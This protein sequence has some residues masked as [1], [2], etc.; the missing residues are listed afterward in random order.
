VIQLKF[1]KLIFIWILFTFILI[2]L[3]A[4]TYYWVGGSGSWSQFGT[5][6][7]T[8]SGGS[9]FHNQ[10]P[11]PLDDVIFDENSFSAGSQTVTLDVHA[12]SKDFSWINVGFNPT[13]SCGGFNLT[14]SGNY[15]TKYGIF[16]L[17]QTGNFSVS[18]SMTID[19]A[20]MIFN[21]TAGTFSV[22]GA[23]N[24]TK[25]N[26]TF[27]TGTGNFSVGG[28]M[29]IDSA[30]VI[31][32]KTAGTFSVVGDLT[33]SNCNPSFTISSSSSI[34][35]NGNTLV[36][37]CNPTTFT[38][39][40]N[41]T[42]SFGGNVTFELVKITTLNWSNTATI[43]GNF[44][45]KGSKLNF[46]IGS[47]TLTCNNFSIL[48]S[49]TTYTQS[50]R[51]YVGGS[52]EVGA[53]TVF[54]NTNTVE[55]TASTIDNTITSNGK[56]FANVQFNGTGTWTLN[57]H[58]KNI[59]VST[60]TRGNLISNGKT[61]DFGINLD[62]S[63]SNTK[64]LNF[65][66]T[67]TVAVRN[68]WNIHSN[69]T[70][71][72]G[73]ATILLKSN[74]AESIT[75]SGGNKSYHNIVVQNNFNSG[76]YDVTFNGNNTFSD[77]LYQ[78]PNGHTG[79]YRRIYFNG[80]S[81]W[82]NVTIN[83]F[84][85]GLNIY[86]QTGP[87]T[88][89]DF[90]VNAPNYISPNSSNY[91]ISAN[92]INSFNTVTLSPGFYWQLYNG[93]NQQINFLNP[94]SS[95]AKSST[96]IGQGATSTITVPSGTVT[97]EFPVLNNHKVQGG[98]TFDATNATVIPTVTG[99]NL[100]T[101]PPLTLYW[102]GGTGNWNDVNRWS[103]TSGGA[104]NGCVFPTSNDNVIFDNNS[105]TAS[106]QTVSLTAT[107]VC[108]NMTWTS[109]VTQNPTFTGSFQLTIFGDLNALGT[110]TWVQ[111][112][113]LYVGGDFILNSNVNWN[114]AHY[115]YFQSDSTNNNINLAGKSLIHRAYFTAATANSNPKWTLL[116]NY[117]GDFNNITT[118]N[119][120][121]FIS[122]GYRVD[123][124]YNLDASSNHT[125]T[126]DFTGTDTVVVRF[127]WSIHANT[128]LTMATANLLFSSNQA[129]NQSM[130]GGNKT[131]HNVIIQNNYNSGFQSFIFSGNNTFNNLIYS[132]PTAHTNS[133]KQ[134]YFQGASTWNDV[135]INHYGSGLQLYFQTG[136]HTFNNFEV[137]V[138]NY[139]TPASTNFYI[140]ANAINTF[141]TFTITN[142][143]FYWQLY[144]SKNQQITSLNI[145]SHCVKRSTIIGGGVS[146]SI[147]AAGGTI[148]MDYPTLST[149]TVQGGAT[150]DAT[151]ATV[152]PVLTGW[153]YTTPTPKTLY[154]VGGSGNWNDAT[155]WAFTSGGSGNGCAYP[156]SIDTVLFDANSFTA[157][158]QTV[159][160]NEN[161]FTKDLSWI[162]VGFNPN[163]SCGSFSLNVAGNYLTKYGKFTFSQT[164]SF[165]VSGS[166]TID[167]ADVTFNK[168][169]GIFSVGG[170]LMISNCNPSF[171]LSS[172]SS[173][174]VTGNTLVYNCNPTTF[175]V[176][177]S[178]TATFGG[179]V[180]FELVKI[181]TLNWTN[182]A[183]IS[184]NFLLKGSK[185]NFNIGNR[186]LSCN[187]F[188]ILDSVTTFTQS[189]RLYVSGSFNLGELTVFNNTN[190]VEFNAASAGK[191][192][193]SNGKI[194][195]NAIFN[196][197]GS[198]TLQDKFTNSGL[199]TF[200]RGHFIS[201]GKS[202][203]F[204]Y[205]L[206][207]SVSNTRT[208]DF[209][210][211]D[212]ITVRNTWSIHTGT[213]LT[214]ATANL[215]FKSNQAESQT[216]SGGNKTYHNIVIQNNYNSGY[217]DIYFSGNNTIN[218]LIYSNPTGHTNS[219]RRIYFQG[220]STW[221]NVTI[222]HYGAGMQI[223]FQS[224]P[225]T[226]NDFILNVPNFIAPA[227]SNFLINANSVNTFN[228]F[229]ISN[230]GFYWQLNNSKNQQITNLSI[231][232]DC[233]KRSTIIG[234][235]VTSTITVPSGSIILEYPTLSTHAVQGGATFDA[236]DATI[237]PTVT[238]WNFTSPPPKTLYWVGGSGNWTDAT[239]WA[240][241][242]GGAGNGCAFPTSIDN[243]IF[244]ANSF[245]ANSQTVTLNA[246]AT[247]KDL[248]WI[249]VGFNPSL[250]CGSFNL[251][252]NGNYLNKYGK[253]TFSQTGNLTVTGS[254]TI[255][256][257]DISFSKTAG[258]LS[259]SG[260]LTIS[261]CN[262]S[263][264]NSSNSTFTVSGNTLV[265][266][267]N[268][269]TFTLGNSS[270]ATFGGNV[271]FELVKITTLNWSN[272]AT[273][274]GNFLLKGSKLNFN[275]G[276]RTLTCKSFS[277][278]DSVT[279][280]TQSNRLYVGGSFELGPLTVFNQTNTVEFTASTSGNTITSSGKSFPNVQFNGTGTWTL[281]DHFKN[282]N[283]STFTRGNLISN[284][285]TVDFG[286][287]LDASSSNTKS[288]N[289]TGTDTVA[290][291]NSWNVHSNTTI[292]MGTASILLKS[293]LAE[294]ITFTGG[295]KTYHNLVVQNNY[296][297][298]WYDVI[299]S[300]NNTFNTF[301]YANP[302]GHTNSYRRLY[303]QGSSNW[304][305]V[306]I[307]HYGAGLL[308]YFQTGPHTFN[309][310]TVNAPNFLAPAS[311][312]YYIDANAINSFNSFTLSPGFY[313][314]LYNSKNQ[315]INYLNPG[316]TCLKR[317]TIAGQSGTLSTI[318]VP[319]GTVNIDWAT[320]SNHKAQGGATFTATSAVIS[321][322]VNGWNAS[323][324]PSWNFYWVGGS[325][326]WSNSNNWAFTS[327]GPGNGCII[328]TAKDNVFFDGNSFTAANQTVTVNTTANCNN[329]IWNGSSSKTP[330]FSGSSQLTIN[331]DLVCN[332]IMTWNLSSILNLYG[333]ITLNSG[334]NWNQTNTVNFLANTTGKTINMAGKS[335]IRDVTFNGN[336]S[337]TLEGNYK[338]DQNGSYNTIFQKG[339]FISNGFSVE[340]GYR[341]YA[342]YNNII[343]FN[344]SGTD[345]IRIR[346]EWTVSTHANTTINTNGSIILLKT[347]L[348]ENITF[349]GGGKSYSGVTILST[350]TSNTAT[351][352]MNDNTNY[353][354]MSITTSNRKDVTI[355]GNCIFNDLTFSLNNN[356][357][358]QVTK[359]NFNG[360]NTF[361][362]ATFLSQGT[363]GPDITLANNNTIGSFVSGGR[364][365]HVFL[366]SAKTQTVTEFLLLGTGSY[367]A[368]L[369]AT[370]TG[371]QA[372]IVK[373]SGQVCMD[374]VWVKDINASG[375]AAFYAGASSQDLGNNTGWTFVESCVGYY[376]VGG[377]GNW[378]DAANHWAT[379]SAG[380]TFWAV[381]PDFSN[382]VY[383]DSNSFDA[384]GQTV[385]L[386][387][388]NPECKNMNWFSVFYSPTFSGSSTD[389]VN[390]YGDL[391]LSSSMNMSFNGKWRFK[392]STGDFIINTVGKILKDVVF[393][394]NYNG[395]G[396]NWKLTNSFTVSDS[397]H[398][399]NGSFNT[400]NH[401]VKTKFF[402]A[403]TQNTRSILLGSSQLTITDGAWK[404]NDA[405]N[406]SITPATSKI[407]L[408]SDGGSCN[409]TGGSKTYN[410]IDL[411]T[412]S[413]ISS[414]FKDSNTFNNF[415]L[416]PGSTLELQNGSVQ[417][418]T[419]FTMSGNCNKSIFIKSDIAGSTATLSQSTGL[420][421]GSF[422]F[423]KDNIASGGATFNANL[424][425]NQGNN[426]GW[427]FTDLQPLSL[428]M[429]KQDASC[430]LP[431]D[432]WAKVIANDGTP[433]YSYLWTTLSVNDSIF[434][435]IPNTY[436]V[437]V[438]DAL[439][440]IAI[441]SAIITQPS[442][443]GFTLTT[444]SGEI[445]PG[446]S[447]GVL[448]VSASSQA[449]YPL[450]YLWS[451]NATDSMPSNFTKGTF[452]VTVTDNANC[453]A[454]ASAVMADRGSLN[455][456][457]SMSKVPACPDE[458]IS[459][460]G[461][462]VQSGNALAFDGSNDYISIPASSGINSKIGSNEITLEAWIYLSASNLNDV[463]II[464]E[465]YLGDN[466]MSF[467]LKMTNQLAKAGFYNGSYREVISTSNI[468]LNSWTHLAATYDGSTIRLYINGTQNNSTNY[469]NTIPG[470][471]EEWRIGRRWDN[472]SGSTSYW[473]GRMDEIRIWNTARTAV[474]I[475][476]NM[477]NTIPPAT[478]GLVAY[479]RFNEGIAG[480]NNSGLD[481][482]SD[483]SGN[484]YKGTLFNFG[485]TGTTSN[486]ISSSIS[487]FVYPSTF[488]FNWDLGDTTTSNTLSLDKSYAYG[489]NKN[490]I[491]T[492]SDTF[493]CS[494]N[495]EELLTV[496]PNIIFTATGTDA[497]CGQCNASVTLNTSG[498]SVPYYLG[499][500]DANY[501]FPIADIDNSIFAKD[502]IITYTQNNQ[503]NLS[504]PSSGW[505]HYFRTIATY[506]RTAGKEF[507]FSFYQPSGNSAMIGWGQSST[508]NQN[509]N[510]YIDIL[511]AFYFQ[512]SNL[513]I[514]EDGNNRG[515]YAGLIPGGYSTNQWYD[516]RIILKATG[517]DYYLRKQGQTNY[518]LIYSSSYSSNTNLRL[519]MS[520]N[521]SGNNVSTDEWRILVPNPSSS[522][523][524]P[525]TNYTYGIIDFAGCTDDLIHTPGESGP[526]IDVKG[527][528]ISITDGDTTPDVSDSTDFGIAET[529]KTIIYKI[530]NSDTFNLIIP[531]GGIFMSGA[532][533]SFF[534]IGGITLPDTLKN[535]S[536]TFTVTFTPGSS[537]IKNAFVN[538]T[539]NDCDEGNYDFKVQAT[540]CIPPQFT[541][542]PG[543]IN[544]NTSTGNCHAVVSYSAIASGNPVPDYSYSFAG[545]T[546][547]SGNGT[548]S[549]AT[550]NKGLT[551]VTIVASNGC[552]PDASCQFTIDVLDNENPSITCPANITVTATTDPPACTYDV[553]NTS[554]DPASF[555][556]NCGGASI[557]NDFNN[558][559][560]LNGAT[561]PYGS[562]LIVW[563][564]TDGSSNSDT[565]SVAVQVQGSIYNM[566]QDIYFCTID[567]AIAASETQNNDELMIPAGT[568]TGCIH[569]IKTIKLMPMG[570][571]VLDCLFMEAPDKTMTLM[572]DITITDLTLTDGH[573]H[574]NGHNLKCGTI[575]GGDIG[576]Y[577]ITD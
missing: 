272:T 319:A 470:G 84:G 101:P 332:D 420:V 408:K 426:S 465:S 524:C 337:W 329:M 245:T 21:K 302:T 339:S 30:D 493:G 309:D 132:N 363:S 388:S 357:N 72:M 54:N 483:I 266:N 335:F 281:N 121:R 355:N 296:N 211:T 521:T 167:S 178:S 418:A 429:L 162:N 6:W 310:F 466:N 222:N 361:N 155:H 292:N 467:Y 391:T 425:T 70:I 299:I 434:G 100:I 57:D 163:F 87:H 419:Q 432:G 34:T 455:P 237:I 500:A 51:L 490:V 480:D 534:T 209:T 298:G 492:V 321:G 75:F 233:I 572:G 215:L 566:T 472:T 567:E 257:A 65:T 133:R 136:A 112:N 294:N 546:S 141:N 8:T 392:A 516:C 387:I 539:N 416:N 181:T 27:T 39:G 122:N 530:I 375:G 464:G 496:N 515:N 38:M 366:G 517:A 353:G 159:T 544:V 371:S 542:C 336:G 37:N 394:G 16:T 452:T 343:S 49:V 223:Y 147:T 427:V 349:N 50:S 219:Y 344:F 14:I 140:D 458:V 206:D 192:I 550:F 241:T 331:G 182:T 565:C 400:N 377:S 529:P 376:W 273:I 160:L 134:I 35:V 414:L 198:W 157:N 285:K 60:F 205:N 230:P 305:N 571:V 338:I 115:L 79:S 19:S 161:A 573:V 118:F 226:F 184:G 545:V 153:T 340:F 239:H 433:P 502:N 11:S 282:T 58:F 212:T 330:I 216:F 156:T 47:R 36:Y 271:T 113:L 396:A 130:A 188:S 202:V 148:I 274:T 512:T 410:N 32:S 456:V 171:N 258:T 277:I 300:G 254:M 559:N 499:F 431:N 196:G 409:F 124:G 56:S 284:G 307:N 81:T 152:V 12:F 407:I 412:N 98:A 532:D 261:N 290:V 246:N 240:L 449:E 401:A 288:L 138:P 235:G 334:I 90:V 99:W 423:I 253:Y 24:I 66:G 415:T 9:T 251:N 88:F 165:S 114:H 399:N 142:P 570:T 308:I 158:S 328:P 108:K 43:T 82:Q 195:S 45:L 149:H 78:N 373:S 146:S 362:S 398:L 525:N 286:I 259:V 424:S 463:Y 487:S 370:T 176:G 367:P 105:F 323:A 311:S 360:S 227:S 173:I 97:I 204:G 359:I 443:F 164:G 248:S 210:G 80:S 348:N 551:T 225:H 200:T 575:S 498:G 129:D 229:T 577:I 150:F 42:A 435:L 207:A 552:D 475:S 372:F 395:T 468:A 199:T 341:L 453:T 413:T 252:V 386:D 527:N 190:Y 102:V 67:D 15:L 440:C 236:T 220:S 193:T 506:P 244:D 95:C 549:G 40:N 214:M 536:T 71:N 568:Y 446:E 33:I 44:I 85:A 293:N 250:S 374:Y 116:A 380:S 350:H 397:I 526:E 172:S 76:W 504:I 187:D 183:N 531:S 120:G 69:T 1:L 538:I 533:A 513:G 547:G 354:N 109:G 3:N 169:G 154:W 189:N 322:T 262:P 18:G 93:K 445:C 106:G 197:T 238:G 91:Y 476:S 404:I 186:T 174:T 519:L 345:T 543:A 41:S 351:I 267:C 119:E 454:M 358:S 232:S 265:Y 22:G 52:F 96:I 508:S 168:T 279:T 381:P 356:D 333:S 402:N 406:L 151:N 554:L 73:T 478:Q 564:V 315:Q 486:W 312:Y 213:N 324:E 497:S 509:S 123:F 462:F 61:V 256:S 243:V 270:T 485:L 450:S 234:G 347:S 474:Q 268:P 325:G 278:L 218:D 379:S 217:Y 421:N 111:N 411:Q 460:S 364:G 511:Y 104:P 26:P 557:V 242:S 430:P 537:G 5:H 520:V 55:F 576:S 405:T 63:S 495:K 316:S 484:N 314:Q 249:N 382:D 264:N 477:N 368:F 473:S 289:F 139:I 451:N 23:L 297:S 385:T 505:N 439:G 548:G 170:D 469:A 166:M 403:N 291:R 558:S 275:I 53:L 144:N 390:I 560:T 13:L 327:G 83:H 92:S 107:A 208:L 507:S 201:N 461:S 94:G 574:T 444:T 59:S 177:N 482:L 442:S 127:S 28:S 303:F 383:F 29:T 318:T 437:T 4:A 503:L 137:N 562:S 224:G 110:F 180:T 320:L 459:L 128:S 203:D 428:S 231:Q 535:D 46:N 247:T 471:T 126:L 117:K 228:T 556:D 422:L 263:F 541:T 438:T 287:N 553:S 64:S 326:N 25:C 7:A 561:L 491:L 563:T 62:A 313:W 522:N 191:T 384:P 365:T 378:S 510:A 135:S 143:G 457:F 528:N 276:S 352:T 2:N 304:Q 417:T 48:D 481:S 346:R 342:L 301:I 103:L 448:S 10:V 145:Q 369:N 221:Q 441:D 479:Y 280:Y 494:S 393:Q 501:A 74:L 523:L 540:G 269:T 306:T 260:D 185:L 179:N 555:D 17:T 488:S 518:T 317:S 447:N 68:S 125:R 295:N 255:D 436:K 389:S 514:Y 31:F 569:V 77:L 20:N 131:Y 283:V 489:G 175:T 194:L 86:F 89:N